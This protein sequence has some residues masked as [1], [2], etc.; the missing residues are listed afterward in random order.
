MPL[1]RSQVCE[2]AAAKLS[3]ALLTLHSV[4]ALVG[5]DGFVDEIIAV[6]DKRHD[7]G[8][9]DPVPT[10]PAMAEKFLRAAGQSCNYELVVKQTKLGGNGPIM[11]N[12][13]AAAGMAVTYLGAVGYPDLHPVFAGLAERA[14]VISV[15]E[16]GHTNALEFQDGKLMLGKYQSLSEITWDLLIQRMGAAQ[17]GESIAASS[18]I[19]MTNWTMIP[20]MAHIWGNFG[21]LL[22]KDPHNRRKFFV[23]LS[24]PEKRTP[25]DILAGMSALTGLQRHADVILGLNLKESAQIAQA[26]GAGTFQQDESATEKIAVAIRSKLNLFCVVVHP[27]RAAAAATEKESAQF[28]GPFVRHPQISTGAGDHFNAG[29]TLAQTLGFSLQES[30]C[31][32][33]ATSGYYVRTAASP[34]A[35]QLAEFI[36]KLPTPE[37]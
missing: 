21:D 29:F 26:I 16:P 6:V 37:Q 35:P 20:H 19:A 22:S 17:M 24:D 14:K 5:L 33:V 13:L 7:S 15:A 1:S 2:S 3:A 32:G 18:L 28:P 31:A 30:L 10:I 23:D 4:N 34:S 12:A 8:R 36:A 25:T 9:Y 27:R 11:A